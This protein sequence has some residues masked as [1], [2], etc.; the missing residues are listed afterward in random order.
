MDGKPSNDSQKNKSSGTWT[1]VIIATVYVLILAGL[2]VYLVLLIQH[3][4]NLN[5]FL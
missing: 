5:P 4:I 2:I 3:P 1:K